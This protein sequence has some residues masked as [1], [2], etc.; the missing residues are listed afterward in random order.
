MQ[1]NSIAST[2]DAA[3]AQTQT[4][5]ALT[6]VTANGKSQ[7]AVVEFTP[8]ASYEAYVPGQP[9]PAATGPSIE[10]AESRLSSTVQLLA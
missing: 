9:G 10:I 1:I 6:H 8:P 3:A 2:I 5:A 7:S 4:L